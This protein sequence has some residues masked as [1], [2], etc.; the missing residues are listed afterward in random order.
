[1]I[2]DFLIDD[3]DRYHPKNWVR[4]SFGQLIPIDSGLGWSHGPLFIKDCIDDILCV[5]IETW[6]LKYQ[7]VEVD[8][9]VKP[10]EKVIFDEY[11]AVWKNIPIE[12]PKICRFSKDMI[13]RLDKL[14]KCMFYIN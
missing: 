9:K 14:S 6:K 5:P 8:K 10:K 12:C 3:H 2:F 4:N 11:N 1:M 7:G 13:N